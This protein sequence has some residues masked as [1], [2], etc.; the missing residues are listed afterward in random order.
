[1]GAIFGYTLV[2]DWLS[3]DANGDPAPPADGPA[4]ALG[5]CIVLADD[6]DPQR[7]FV[8]ARVDG[9]VWAKGNLNGT[10]TNLAGVVAAASRS[11]QL[12]AADAFAASPFDGFARGQRPLWPGAVVE[13]D[14]E[15]IGV[16]RTRLGRRD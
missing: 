4:I 15:G 5:P 14:A 13:L 2:N 10:A 7:M 8:T 11:E 16:L 3:R 1:V 12:R 9:V 6:I